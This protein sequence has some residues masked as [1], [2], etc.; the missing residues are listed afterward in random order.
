M[1]RYL[2]SYAA[3]MAAFVAAIVDDA[4]VP[5]TGEDGRAPVVMGLAARRS[6]D[7]NRPV[8]LDEICG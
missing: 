3:E 8:R 2:E 1:E 4:P 6:F 5:V 7:E